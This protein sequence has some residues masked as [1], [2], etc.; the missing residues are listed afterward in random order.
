[1]A[2]FN[3]QDSEGFPLFQLEEIVVS[4]FRPHLL[5]HCFKAIF[6]PDIQKTSVAFFVIQKC[7]HGP[8]EEKPLK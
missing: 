1:M 4:L 5:K 6:I 3:Y 7:V 8:G 2:V